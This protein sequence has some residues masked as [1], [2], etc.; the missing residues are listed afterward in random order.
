[1][2]RRDRPLAPPVDTLEDRVHPKRL[3]Q[4][5]LHPRDTP[6]EGLSIVNQANREAATPNLEHFIYITLFHRQKTVAKK[7]NK[8]YVQYSQN[9]FNI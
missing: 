5:Q 3:P 1:M 4:P 8:K 6:S 2:K 7:G 9:K